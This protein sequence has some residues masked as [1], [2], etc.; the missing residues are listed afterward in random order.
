MINIKYVKSKKKSLLVCCFL[1]LCSFA[2]LGQESSVSNIDVPL[3]V[4][5]DFWSLNQY[6]RTD[7]DEEISNRQ[8]GRLFAENQKTD[9][10]YTN[11]KIFRGVAIASVSVLAGCLVVRNGFTD[12][13]KLQV[14]LDV[15]M[16][17][18]AGTFLLSNRICQ[19]NLDKAVDNYNMLLLNKINEVSAP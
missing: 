14:G 8:L 4:H 7:T 18:S 19:N 15:G 17:I 3:L 11:Y 9:S 2:V 10:Y 13:K 12:N 6:K 16:I 5:T 1:F